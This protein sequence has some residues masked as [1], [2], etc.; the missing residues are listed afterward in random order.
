MYVSWSG[1]KDSTVMLHLVRRIAPDIDVLY[2]SSGYTLP[3]TAVLIERL[4]HEWNLH[5]HVL[6]APIDYIELCRTFGLP[7]TRSRVSQKKVV[8]ILKKDQASAWASSHGFD[9]LFWGIRAEES[10]GRAAMCRALPRGLRDGKGVLRLAPIAEWSAEDVW[11]YTLTESIAYSGLYDRENCG[12]T[13]EMLRNTG[14]LSTDGAA[15]GRLE[16]LRMNY[17]EQFQKVR[18]LL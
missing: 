1:G 9:G 6:D 12:F 15:Y 11:A 17:P 8:K 7:H 10:V 18:D 16:W 13:R 2:M 14:W 5:L 4:R 3:D